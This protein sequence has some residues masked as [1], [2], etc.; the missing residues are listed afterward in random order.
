M[1]KKKK[2][3][4]RVIRKQPNKAGL[5]PQQQNSNEKVNTEKT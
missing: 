3:G 2:N 5:I 1:S 4:T